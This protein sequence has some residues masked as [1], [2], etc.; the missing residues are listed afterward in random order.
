MEPHKIIPKKD[1]LT[2]LIRILD[3][4]LN[5]KFSDEKD[6]DFMLKQLKIARNGYAQA[7]DT[8]ELNKLRRKLARKQNNQ[9]KDTWRKKN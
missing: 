9:E 6:R 3:I 7:T 5:A 1:A 4:Y 8:F 2:E